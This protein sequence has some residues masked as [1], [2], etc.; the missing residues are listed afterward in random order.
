[1]GHLG[2][3]PDEACFMKHQSFK[4]CE[5]ISREGPANGTSRSIPLY[6]GILSPRNTRMWREIGNLMRYGAPASP[7][8]HG[9][10]E[11][12]STHCAILKESKKPI[13]DSLWIAARNFER[14]SVPP[15]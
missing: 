10:T 14:A 13:A 3:W 7:R 12:H 11:A 15:W 9:N 4:T 8:R 6:I 2:D 1:M 5:F